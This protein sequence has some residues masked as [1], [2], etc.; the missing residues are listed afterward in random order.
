[1]L[2][3]L[4]GF[5][6]TVSKTIFSAFS[7]RCF[8]TSAD[9]TQHFFLDADFAQSCEYDDGYGRVEATAAA[10]LLVWP[11]GVPLFFGVLLYACRKAVAEHR[12]T[13]LSKAILFLTR[14]YTDGAY[15]W[16]VTAPP[17]PA[18]QSHEPPTLSA[19]S[20]FPF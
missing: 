6:P 18:R 8:A 17:L 16:E 13:P 12:T 19:L 11:I 10:L 1:M 2:I 3:A 15:W 9:G 4:F 14:E 5:V 7:C 20:P